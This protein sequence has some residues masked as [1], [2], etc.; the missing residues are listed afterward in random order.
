MKTVTIGRVGCDIIIP[1]SN[2]SR[3]HATISLVDGQYVYTDMSKN[4]TTI[5]GQIIHNDKVV[6]AP[7]ATIY[8]A[9]KVPLPW[10]Q[11]LM[12][13]PQQGVRVENNHQAPP[14][15]PTPQ[16]AAEEESIN[17]FV[18]IISVIIPLVGFIMYFVWKKEYPKKAKQALNLAWIGFFV[19]FISSQLINLLATM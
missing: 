2:V 5:N 13:L 10:A 1:D 3:Q 15:Q 18:G 19:N 7:G 6:V 8:L 4:G 11:V 14:A 16:P 12:L 17:V 9:N